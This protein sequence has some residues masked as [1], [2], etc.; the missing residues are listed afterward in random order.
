MEDSLPLGTWVVCEDFNMVEMASEKECNLHFQWIVGEREAWYYMHN[1]LGLFYLNAHSHHSS[2]IQHTWS[3][4]R[5]GT[6]KIFKRI[7]HMM[8]SA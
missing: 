1:K 3:N 4:F 5:V 2:G 6:N 7:D 8:I